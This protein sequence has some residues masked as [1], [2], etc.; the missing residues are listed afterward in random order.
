FALARYNQDGSL[1]PSFGT[2]GQV[3]TNCCAV[4]RVGDVGLQPGGRIIVAGSGASAPFSPAN[5]ALARSNQDG[6]L[7]AS[8]GTGGQVLT[9]FSGGAALAFA[10]ALQPDGQIVA[11]GTL[12]FISGGTSDFALARYNGDGSL[13]A[14]FGTGGQVLTN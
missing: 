4:G 3:L 12:R 2:G 7:D 6:S 14:S 9:N 13:D 1:D 10:M 5:L 11:A 8:F